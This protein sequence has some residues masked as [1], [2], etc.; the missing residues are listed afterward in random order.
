VSRSWGSWCG[1]V[2]SRCGRTRIMASRSRRGDV[3]NPGAAAG[4]S[5]SAR[6]QGRAGHHTRSAAPRPI[7][8]VRSVSPRSSRRSGQRASFSVS[9]LWRFHLSWPI[10]AQTR[11]SVPGVTA[12][13]LIGSLP[14]S[15]IAARGRARD[16]IG[17]HVVAPASGLPFHARSALPRRRLEA[18]TTTGQGLSCLAAASVRT[19]GDSPGTLLLD[20]SGY[21]G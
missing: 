11:G 21:G 10:D 9:H 4:N 13:H 18:C 19:A 17:G 1:N 7:E 20:D 16:R 14:H 3:P 2:P 12:A 15:S 5:W 6:G 8:T